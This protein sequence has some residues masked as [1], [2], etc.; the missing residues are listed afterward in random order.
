MT[1][2]G[3]MCSRNLLRLD[4]SWEEAIRSMLPICD[5]ISISDCD[6]SDGTMMALRW[7]A[8]KEPKIQ[9]CH[10]PWQNPVADPSWYPGWLNHAREH[11]ETDYAIYL[12]ADEVFDEK[13]YPRIREAAEKG[14]A[15]MCYRYNFWRDP[16]HLI[17]VGHCCGV[18]VIRC[19]PQRM[20][21]PSDY[22][23]LRAKEISDI[24]Q[25]CE[26]KVYHY[27]FLRKREAFFRKSRATQQIWSG[28]YDERLEKA[29]KHDGPWSTMPGVTGW[30]DRL[31]EFIGTHP[32]VIKPWLRERG[33]ECG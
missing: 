29:E 25:K 32:E 27:G 10:F 18:D 28:F 8:S 4:Y 15:L 6:S 19:G 20:F 22:P 3:F 33:Y 16:Q 11:L 30:E 7:L 21:F 26:V 13:D 23:D 2:G 24:A 31:D 5:Q 14:E 9:I 1:I 12:D 17:P